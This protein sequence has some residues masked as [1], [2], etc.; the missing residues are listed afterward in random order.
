MPVQKSKV[1][2]KFWRG[3]DVRGPDDCWPWRL[4]RT[5]HGGYGQFTHGKGVLLKAHRVA[6]EI[7][8]GA[9]PAGMFVCHTCGNAACCNPA[10]L[11][12][13]TPADNW[14]DTRRMGRAHA[15]EVVRGE[16]APA[17]KLTDAVVQ[18][19]RDSDE[20]GGVLSRRFGVSRTTISHIRRGKTWKHL[21]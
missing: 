8:N 17:A 10:H 3:V 14:G 4:S 16:D 1:A 13:G 11:Y 21:L 5:V 18:Q 2:D 9:V 20:S 12:A 15:F 7:H 6:Y 19:I